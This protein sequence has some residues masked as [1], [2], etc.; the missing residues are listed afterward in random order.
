MKIGASGRLRLRLSVSSA[1]YFFVLP[2][3]WFNKLNMR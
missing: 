3:D 1:A 2:E